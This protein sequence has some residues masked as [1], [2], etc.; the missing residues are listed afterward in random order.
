MG[1]TG[2]ANTVTLTL[3]KYQH[4]TTLIPLLEVG[5]SQWGIDVDGNSNPTRIHANDGP[6]W[7]RTVGN[8]SRGGGLAHENRPPYY[9]LCYIIKHTATSGSGGIR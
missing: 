5:P 7:N 2:G 3:T 8:L 4:I 1:A 9:A 6:P